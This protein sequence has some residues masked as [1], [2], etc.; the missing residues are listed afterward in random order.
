MTEARQG[1]ATVT[2]E[3]EAFYAQSMRLMVESG[4]PFLL[5][6]TYAVSAYTGI[7]RPTKD[8]DVFCRG[9]DFPRI[10]AHF[11]GHGFAT[12]IED[13]R[14][15]GKVKH[16]DLF[17]DVIFNSAAAINPVTDRWFEEEHRALI[18]GTDV[19][20]VAPTEMIF[21]KSFVQMRHKYDGPDV[22]HLIL[23][24]HDRIDWKR[25]LAHMEQHWEV[26][27]IHALNFRFIYPT[28]R[29]RIPEWLVDELLDRMTERAKLPVAQTRICRGR[30]FS[31]EDYRIDVTEWGFADVVGEETKHG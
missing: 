11:Q 23:K 2:P 13:E 16:G 19:Q 30:L 7:T 28:E 24:Q 4:I 25:L 20:L 10:L 26:L 27:L 22:A 12:E 1:S 29:D 31:R 5:G 8:I 21:S 6:G 14:W 9:G 17:F 18:C 3:A 15:I